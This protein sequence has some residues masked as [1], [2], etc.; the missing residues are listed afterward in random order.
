M[1]IYHDKNPQV[2][3]A[4]QVSAPH[5]HCAALELIQERWNQ[6][7]SG[8]WG[9]GY[10]LW[11]SYDFPP[12]GMNIHKSQLFWG[13]APGFWLIVKVG[14]SHNYV[15]LTFFWV[16]LHHFFFCQGKLHGSMGK[17]PSDFPVDCLMFATMRQCRCRTCFRKK[18]RAWA[19][20]RPALGW[21]SKWSCS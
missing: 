19:P 15:L 16:F 5:V 13:K 14:S 4:M 18:H 6:R 20:C 7:L 11:F 3:H 1:R 10:T 21:R 17:Q 12:R 9:M 8:R 2:G